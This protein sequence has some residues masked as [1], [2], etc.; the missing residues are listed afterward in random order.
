M[1]NAAP[2][3]LSRL[4][5]IVASEGYGHGL[6][7]VQLQALRY[8]AN[9]NRFSR[10]PRALTAWLGQTKGTVS[11][12]IASLERRGLVVRSGDTRD[13]RVIRLELTGAGLTVARTEGD[14]ASSMLA[15]L[16]ENERATAEV[17]LGWPCGRARISSDGDLSHLPSF[18]DWRSSG[19]FAPLCATW[20]SA[21]CRRCTADLHRTGSCMTVSVDA[22]LVG[23]VQPF[24][25]STSAIAKTAVPDSLAVGFFG[26]DG[27]SQAD[28]SVHGGPDKA[29]HHYPRDHYSFWTEELGPLAALNMVGAFGE[30]IST[31]GVTE[32]DVCIGD[33][34]RLGTALVE[35]SQGRQPCWKQGHRLN[36]PRVVAMMVRTTRCG[37]YYRVIEEGQVKAGDTLT[38]L[39]RPQPEWTVERVIGLLIG[40]AGKRDAE[41]VAK[42]ASMEVLAPNWRARAQKMVPL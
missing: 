5:R 16:D 6:K 40:G 27:D 4:A 31:T 38:L 42:L 20:R 3:L 28:L 39:S 8:L 15:Y 24:G 2:S 22:V 19:D 9:A 23:Q 35:V 7:P 32:A 34:Y 36:E 12:T 1:A 29:I 33:R 14:I 30:N 11:Q 21:R 25:D 13:R 18:S 41:A 26:I 17:L 37:W 10:T